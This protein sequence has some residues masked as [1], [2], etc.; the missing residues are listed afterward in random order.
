M[1]SKPMNKQRILEE[2]RKAL[3]DVFGDYVDGNPDEAKSRIGEHTYIGGEDPGDWA[4]KSLV[5]ILAECIPLP[6]MCEVS[7]I[8]LWMEASDKI[9][10][11]FIE[12]INNAVAAVWPE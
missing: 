3:L 5:V 10:G 1:G 7:Q 6:E 2:T 8:E 12:H 4:S 9:K 11:G